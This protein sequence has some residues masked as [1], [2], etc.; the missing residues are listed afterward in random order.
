MLNSK[1]INNADLALQVQ[2]RS[3]SME[4]RINHRV[5]A[6]AKGE[7]R[8]PCCAVDAKNLYLS[9]IDTREYQVS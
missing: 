6:K 2:R 4:T 3:R 9:K 7:S 5:K 1:G 8:V